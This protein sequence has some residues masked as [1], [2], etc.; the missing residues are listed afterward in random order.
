[1][2]NNRKKFDK[3]WPET[4][5]QLDKKDS[6]DFRWRHPSRG[7]IGAVNQPTSRFQKSMNLIEFF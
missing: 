2:F 4:A 7:R 6:A 3:R 5:R 1:M